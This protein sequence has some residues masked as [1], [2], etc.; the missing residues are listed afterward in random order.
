MA[1]LHAFGRLIGNTDMHQ[2]NI[3]FHLADR[4]PLPLSPA[5]DMLPMSLAP[6]RTS[7]LR[8]TSP[9][10]PVAPLRAGQL[11]HLQ[12]AAPLAEDCWERVADSPLLRSTVLR[13]V[14]GENA[15][16]VRAMG[17]RYG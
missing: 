14:A 13:Q 16:R 9:M 8:P 4:G 1:Q 11:A 3:G 5:Y 6:S 17:Q 15:R 2:G 12:W 7:V 10:N